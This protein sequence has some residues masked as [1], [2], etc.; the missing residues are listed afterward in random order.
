[1]HTI[2]AMCEPY[3]PDKSKQYK[4]HI[5][6]L[7]LI[8]YNLFYM[9]QQYTALSRRSEMCEIKKPIPTFGS[10]LQKVVMHT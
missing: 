9:L 7:S 1:M 8:P 6:T 10:I 4:L 3:R 2:G 5:I